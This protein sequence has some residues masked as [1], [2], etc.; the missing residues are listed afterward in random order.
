MIY[1]NDESDKSIR[2]KNYILTCFVLP[3][4][5]GGCAAGLV[6]TASGHHY[7]ANQDITMGYLLSANLAIITYTYNRRYWLKM[8]GRGF[9][10]IK[11]LQYG[12][13]ASEPAEYDEVF[14]ESKND[15]WT[16]I[17]IGILVFLAGGYLLSKG[18]FVLVPGSM[19]LTSVYLIYMNIKKLRDKSPHLKLAKQGL[20]TKKL[21]FV[22]WKNVVKAD[23]IEEDKKNNNSLYLDIYLKNTVFAEAGKPDER[24]NINGLANKEMIETVVYQMIRQQEGPAG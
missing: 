15:K 4:F 20:W 24:L 8:P 19:M 3:L 18:G 12:K 13:F 17:L 10:N 14:F 21:G 23:V 2:F 16:G 5:L 7:L 22:E 11:G 6:Y 1:S 9:Y